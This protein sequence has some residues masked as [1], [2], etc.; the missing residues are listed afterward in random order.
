[1]D[2][3]DPRMLPSLKLNFEKLLV[4]EAWLAERERALCARRGCAWVRGEL[5]GKDTEILRLGL[6]S[7]QIRKGLP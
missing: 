2:L 5:G 4:R 6:P 1:M 3:L 7:H